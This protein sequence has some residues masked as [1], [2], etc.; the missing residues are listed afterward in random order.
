MKIRRFIHA[1]LAL[2]LLSSLLFP[3]LV[4]ASGSGAGTQS[5]VITTSA[6]TSI[7]AATTVDQIKTAVQGFLGQYG[8]TIST[9]QTPP[10]DIFSD[11]APTDGDLTIVKNFSI[12]FVEEWSKY[13]PQWISYSGLSTVYVVKDLNLVGF[14]ASSKRCASYSNSSNYMVYDVTCS[15]AEYY[16]RSVVHHEFEH[17]LAYE[18]NNSNVFDSPT[19]SSYNPVDFSYG[20][21]GASVYGT[22]FVNTE[23]PSD[24]FVT[25]YAKTA[26]AEDQAEVYSYLFETNNYQKL[27]SWTAN[28]TILA[29]KVS[30]MKSYIL[31]A[32]PSMDGTYIA[33]I[34]SYALDA[35]TMISAPPFT[36]PGVQTYHQ[37]GS[38]VWLISNGTNSTSGIGVGGDPNYRQ[39]LILDGTISGGP[40]SGINVDVN[41]I[42]MGNG[43]V[44]KFIN[45][46]A[47]GVLAPGHSPGCITT[48]GLTLNGTYQVELGGT[49]PCTG[50]DQV[51]VNGLVDV[52][53]GILN[54]SLYNNFKPTAGESFIVINNDGADAIVGTLAGLPEGASIT[55]SGVVY[56]ISYKGGDGNDLALSVQLVP[57]TPNTGFVLIKSNPMVTIISTLLSASGIMLIAYRLNKVNSKR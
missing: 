27:T 14:G 47:G 8:L 23:H 55:V 54:V 37:D 5:S 18:N 29:Q 30:R 15:D 34:H 48:G 19:W 38:M 24:G 44:E 13:T 32:D 46:G 33:A 41:G 22:N 4:H 43:S 11:S 10:A 20:N 28:D 31:A 7:K 16:M 1:S 21:G 36:G 17:F 39:T 50:Y 9:S 45:V 51:T 12:I 42:L 56:K 40:M 6:L 52:T 57:S 2:V 26:M 53:N 25:N 49:T 35:N 3:N